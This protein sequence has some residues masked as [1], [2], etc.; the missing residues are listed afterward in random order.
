MQPRNLQTFTA[1]RERLEQAGC[2]CQVMAAYGE[3]V[4]SDGTPTPALFVIERTEDDGT[5][6]HAV[7]HIYEPSLPIPMTT[8]RSVYYALRLGPSDVGL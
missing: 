6:R 8:I 4:D 1:F 2:A 3:M 5:I 7:L